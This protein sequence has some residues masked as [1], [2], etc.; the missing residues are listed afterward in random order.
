MWGEAEL[1]HDLAT[2]QAMW[3]RSDLPFDPAMFF[4]TA[5][6]PDHALVRITPSRA[7]V[8]TDDGTGPR[9]FRWHR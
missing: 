3:A 1:V 4:G 7:T 8:M 6:D 5:D 9:A 2:K